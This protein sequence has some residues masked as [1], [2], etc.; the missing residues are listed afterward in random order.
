MRADSAANRRSEVAISPEREIGGGGAGSSHA[1]WATPTRQAL[2][3]P[4]APALSSPMTAYRR[5]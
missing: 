2:E 4:P 5:L 3:A 1:A